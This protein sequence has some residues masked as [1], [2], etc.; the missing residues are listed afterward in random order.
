MKIFVNLPRDI[1]G[2]SILRDIAYLIHCFW[3]TLHFSIIHALLGQII[4][5]T[6]GI[7]LK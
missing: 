4:L 1:G 6:V 2:D 7:F 3:I 5:Q